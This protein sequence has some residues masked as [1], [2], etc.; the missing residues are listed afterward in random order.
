MPAFANTST[1]P[2]ISMK[3]SS[4]QYKLEKTLWTEADFDLMEWH[5]NPIH[6]ITFD[7]NFQLLL[8]IDYIFEWVL[9]GNTYSFWISPCTLIFENVHELVFDVG[10]AT[11]GFNIDV[12]TKTNPQTPRNSMHINRDTEFDWTIDLQEGVISFKSVGFKQYVRRLPNLVKTQK[13]TLTQRDG[14]S[15]ATTLSP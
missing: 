6:G 15:F 11:P 7:D 8:D 4:K 5:D 2:A 12:V 1:L 13:L 3:Q 14:L 10:P 9:T